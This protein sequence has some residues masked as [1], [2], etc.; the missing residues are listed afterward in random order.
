MSGRRITVTIYDEFAMEEKYMRKRK[1][2]INWTVVFAWLIGVAIWVVVVGVPT[3]Y[4]VRY[5]RAKGWL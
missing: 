3:F 5:F 4:L 2:N 1:F